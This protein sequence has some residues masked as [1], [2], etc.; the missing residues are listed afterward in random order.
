MRTE[1]P[2]IRG[3][4]SSGDAGQIPGIRVHY[5]DWLRALAVLGVF[6]Y[7]S[8]QPFS[9]HD[10]H[11]KNDQL[12]DA[13]DGVISFVDPWGIAFFFLI[14]GASTFLALRWR[15]TGQYLRERLMRLLVPLVV[16]YLLLSPVQA[17]IEERHFGRYT[18]SFV[19][20]L[21]LFFQEVWSNLR[22]TMSHPLLVDRTYHL[23]FVVFLLWLSLLGLPMFLWLRGPE[24]RRLSAWL[25]DRAGRRGSTLLFAVP[26][27]L[28]PLTVL[29]L[30]PEA[31]DWGTFVYLFGFFVAGYVL[32][33]DPRLM[34]A[35]RR[36]VV[37]ALCLAIVGDVAILLTGVPAFV[38]RWQDAPSYSWMYA[39][40]Y[41]LIGVQA[42]AWVQVL[43]GLGMRARSF[44]R[45]LPRSVS[46]A[47]MPFFIV[48]QPVILAI[49]F[50]VVRWDAGIAIK[51]G[52]IVLGSFSISAAV[53]TTLARLPIVSMIFG[54][55]SCTRSVTPRTNSSAS[56]S[57]RDRRTNRDV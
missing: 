13:I 45:P 1:R 51:W 24:G 40:A 11:V 46:A 14:A 54:V 33:S 56:R 20:G 6:V 18:G 19:S 2:A 9:T 39:W 52:V 12:S 42:W 34:D 16:A 48:H 47:A 55:K 26:V 53:A 37:P 25:G 30:W 4:V 5:V 15:T 43:L 8:L 28:V 29:P 23:W 32:M 41:F 21:P 35:V 3:A 10:W 49:A 38:E 50:F 44:Q 27:A 7:H 57:I 22:E 31:E 17:Y 36:G